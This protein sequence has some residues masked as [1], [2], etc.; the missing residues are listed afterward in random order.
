[1]PSGQGAKT[2]RIDAAGDFASLEDHCRGLS[3]RALIAEAQALI[4]N[5]PA[6]TGCL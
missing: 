6:E 2:T 5:R 4:G 3:G 1:M